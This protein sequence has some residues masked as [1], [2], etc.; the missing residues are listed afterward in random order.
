MYINT[1]VL[2]ALLT[3][4]FIVG[5]IAT[6]HVTSK[7][8]TKYT[9]YYKARNLESST[10]SIIGLDSHITNTSKFLLQEQDTVFVNTTTLKVD[11]VDSIAMKYVILEPIKTTQ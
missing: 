6:F 7:E 2:V 10:A 9:E 3:T 1:Y 11:E 4:S 8:P 5:S